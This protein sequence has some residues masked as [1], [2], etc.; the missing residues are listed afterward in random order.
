[1][2]SLLK[3]LMFRYGEAGAREQFER[4]CSLLIQSEYPDARAV[5]V[6]MGD[7][8]VDTSVGDWTA[9]T[10]I[11]VFQHK[12]FS[13][14]GDAQKKQI[15]KAYATARKNPLFILAK[16]ILCLPIDL[17]GREIEWWDTWKGNQGCAIELW[18]ALTIEGLLAK[19]KNAG[20]RDR[21]FDEEYKRQIREIHSA[22][23]ESESFVIAQ[24]ASATCFPETVPE[25]YVPRSIEF[26]QLRDLLFTLNSVDP[27]ANIVG[28]HGAGGFGKTTLAAMICQDSQ[29][30]QAF[31][32]GIY[33]LTLGQEPDIS[34]LLAHLYSA[35]TRKPVAS[36]E[37]S[38]IAKYLDGKRYLVVFDD[39]WEPGDLVPLLRATT[40][41]MR[42]VTSRNS[43]V[44]PRAHWVQIGKMQ[45]HEAA[46]MLAAQLGEP[47]PDSSL[48][49]GLARQLGG[50]PLLLEL[51]GK[52]L[53]ERRAIT[54]TFDDAL[55]YVITALHDDGVLAFDPEDPEDKTNQRRAI[56]STLNLSINQ[57]T[58]VQQS[59]YMDL[60][61][62]RSGKTVPLTTLQQLWQLSSYQTEKLVGRLACLS[63]VQ[64][65]PALRTIRLHE[66]IRQY[67]SLKLK[68]PEEV[69]QRLV[70]TW[71][72]P[73][74]LP[75]LF[76]WQNYVYHLIESQQQE[77]VYSLL[78]N[79][80]WIQ[81]R[82]IQGE[83]NGSNFNSIPTW[84]L[85]NDYSRALE[86]LPIGQEREALV[87]FGD[88]LR[89]ESHILCIRP[90][91]IPSQLYNRL[92][93]GDEAV[94]DHLLE[95]N[96]T[97]DLLTRPWLRVTQPLP[98]A[99]PALRRIL[100][101][102]MSA[103]H[104]EG[105]VIKEG[106]R[107]AGAVRSVD[108]TRKVQRHEE[109]TSHAKDI[110]SEDTEPYDVPANEQRAVS[111]GDD[112]T[113][114][115]WNVVTGE[116]EDKGVLTGHDGSVWAVA[117]SADGEVA[118]S[119]GDDGTVR[120]WDVGEG[121]VE[122]AT[123]GRHDGSVW[124]VALSADGEVA[125]SGGDDGTVRI[126]DVGN[127]DQ[128]RILARIGKP[129]RALAI[130]PTGQIMAG[131]DVGAVHI[132][133]PASGQYVVLPVSQSGSAVRT[134]A[135]STDGCLM[136]SGNA[137]GRIR[138]W[139]RD[140]EKQLTEWQGHTGGVWSL[141]VGADNR[142]ISG[143]AD[144][145]IRIWDL[146]SGEVL[147]VLWGHARE[148]WSLAIHGDGSVVSGGDD[149]TIRVWD[150]ALAEH[151]DYL[152]IEY[153]PAAPVSE[154]HI[155]AVNS[156]SISAD[157]QLAASGG[158]DSTVRI[159]DVGT[160]TQK[161]VLLG[162]TNWIWAVAL[163]G[164]GKLAV[165][166][167]VD[168]VFRIWDVEDETVEHARLAVHRHSDTIWGVSISSDGLWASSGS[169]DG[170]VL[171]W[172]TE[173][174]KAKPEEL[175]SSNKAVM[176]VGVSNDG[177]VAVSGG[178]DFQIRIW[179]LLGTG[180][181]EVKELPGH[182][183]WVR[184]L[185]VSTNGRVA[186]SS[187]DDGTVRAWDIIAQQEIATMHGCDQPVWVVRVNSDGTL[188]VSGGDDGTLRVWD[189]EA[190]AELAR[191]TWDVPIYA[192]AISPDGRI[193]LAGDAR[194]ALLFF[195]F[196]NSDTSLVTTK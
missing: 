17:S 98:S 69:H 106:Q 151:R 12:Y 174:G 159:W 89:Y 90:E 161:R 134:V 183:K 196:E 23:A 180:K 169:G 143:G 11:T 81:T 127:P 68:G 194:G 79:L 168:Q 172:N 77:R 38:T 104:T 163:S 48:L 165:S 27:R 26:K 138:V 49:M 55:S 20:I 75:D 156:V 158:A 40:G 2:S 31:P 92:W 33:W 113:L 24:T 45:L 84:S 62:F 121:K 139:H 186:V 162:H 185:G 191:Y 170:L 61:I 6:V 15:R 157:G 144:G 95:T 146:V 22:V 25:I 141:A 115:V 53:Q 42:L 148:V 7:G 192:C 182:T 29:V 132:W 93:R 60:A 91:D 96:R 124:A 171:V 41:C 187:G 116:P 195:A 71:G 114:R 118:V 137:D 58:D 16:W 34:A 153:D 43:S 76:A 63:L 30:R 177:R 72:D 9:D 131:D 128:S 56:A 50:W 82:L 142:V 178:E 64:F 86:M 111:G 101:G 119:G 5:R 152:N 28:L 123:L 102:H 87:A 21:F 154:G 46:D 94:V 52:V 100:S 136:V 97:T 122:I 130:N 105:V 184:S 14:L 103:P 59:Q 39:V 57:L 150:P 51:A 80:R 190:R 147:A 36:V 109:G 13:K 70:E 179:Q 66:V 189:L 85:E 83:S 129:V 188:A 126:W 108:V 193:I 175:K 44:I 164:D 47:V 140:E 181:V 78:T 125:V 120:I 149:G 88:A 117:L 10:S 35:L 32:D 73:Y 1:M 18:S 173:S 4:M 65:E 67:L 166:G 176:G 8:G 155:G 74:N 160:G 110:V 112:G 133:G 135:F 3:E 99:D 145:L 107:R 54:Y 167:G 19:P 37:L